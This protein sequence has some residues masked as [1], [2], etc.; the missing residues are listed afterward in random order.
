M[1]TKF[2]KQLELLNVELSLLAQV[3]LCPSKSFFLYG[4]E[5]LPA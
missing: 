1:R 4:T 3:S 5:G 2:D